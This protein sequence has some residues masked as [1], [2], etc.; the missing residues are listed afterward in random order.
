MDKERRKFLYAITLV[1][2]DNALGAIRTAGALLIGNSALLFYEVIGKSPTAPNHYS[3][4]LLLGVS[5]TLI[6][7]APVSA[8]AN[9]I[10]K[11]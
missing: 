10:K 1:Y 8:I 4:V 3:A 11:G 7:S 2:A 9:L 6:G 5:L